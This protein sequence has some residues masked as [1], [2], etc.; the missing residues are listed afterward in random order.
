MPLAPDNG[1]T[2]RPEAFPITKQ[3]AS[4]HVNSPAPAASDAAIS[5]I[6]ETPLKSKKY[7]DDFECTSRPGVLRPPYTCKFLNDP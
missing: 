1:T 4:H 7:Y 5:H 3:G 6:S 2:A